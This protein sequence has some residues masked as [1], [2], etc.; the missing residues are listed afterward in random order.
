L[1]LPKIFVIKRIVDPNEKS[2][3]Q[4]YVQLNESEKEFKYSLEQ[5]GITFVTNIIQK[6]VGKEYSPFESKGS[7]KATIR[8]W[9]LSN[10]LLESEE[11]LDI[12]TVERSDNLKSLCLK[13]RKVGITEIEILKEKYVF[14]MRLS[15]K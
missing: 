5:Y 3:L 8:P 9:D 1:I 10:I 13:L 11:I 7:F 2:F 15:N 12:I 14:K 4:K 6:Y